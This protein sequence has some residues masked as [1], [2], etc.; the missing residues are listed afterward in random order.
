MFSDYFCI[1]GESLY[2]SHDPELIEGMMNITCDKGRIFILICCKGNKKFWFLY[3][4]YP[5]R[6]QYPD[7]PRLS[8]EEIDATMMANLD[9][10]VTENL[11]PETLWNCRSKCTMVPFEEGVLN[12]WY[13]NKIVC[14]G[15][16]VYKVLLQLYYSIA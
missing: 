13:A 2:K 10:R 6:Y 14:Q 3:L 5:T 16:A 15:D 7:I 11:S 1:L 8:P 9:I 12:R 4:K